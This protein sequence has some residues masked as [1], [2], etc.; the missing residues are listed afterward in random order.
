MGCIC[1]L[2]NFPSLS[3]LIKGENLEKGRRV[4]FDRILANLVVQVQN[5][6]QKP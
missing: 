1:E 2:W 5:H 4:N 3:I 6:Q